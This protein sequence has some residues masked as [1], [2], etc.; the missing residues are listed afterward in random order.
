MDMTDDQVT[1]RFGDIVEN[2]R[3]QQHS[4]GY[5][6]AVLVLAERLGISTAQADKLADRMDT[7]RPG[8]FTWLVRR[9]PEDTLRVLLED[10]P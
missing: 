4:Q 10:I 1:A 7:A 5:Q 3:K 8:N 9:L 2:E 6:T